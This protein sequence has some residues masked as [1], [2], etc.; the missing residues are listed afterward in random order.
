MQAGRS[1]GPK[2]DVTVRY[3]S[4]E[5]R[6]TR[7]RPGRSVVH[8]AAAFHDRANC[9]PEADAWLQHHGRMVLA[10]THAFGNRL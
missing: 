3:V 6:L 4:V 1:R 9:A 10:W 2:V 7:S 5:Q 8:S